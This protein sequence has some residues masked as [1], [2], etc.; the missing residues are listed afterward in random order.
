MDTRTVKRNVILAIVD[1]TTAIKCFATGRIFKTRR[2]SSDREI[3]NDILKTQ[4]AKLQ[5]R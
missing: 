1:E 3:I 5:N 4:C 2:D